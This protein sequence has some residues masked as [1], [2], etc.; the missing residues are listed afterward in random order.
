[1]STE[2]INN[3][4]TISFYSSSSEQIIT[5]YPSSSTTQNVLTHPV[6]QSVVNNYTWTK[7][8]G[9]VYSDWSIISGTN[10]I[11]VMNPYD[12]NNTLSG[13]SIGARVEIRGNEIYST[14]FRE[15]TADS[16]GVA[17]YDSSSS[18]WYLKDFVSVLTSSIADPGDTSELNREFSLDQ[19]YMIIPATDI[20]TREDS[21]LFIFKS[22]SSGWAQEQV[23][24]T[25]SYD[26]GA[27][28]PL[29][30]GRY[31]FLSPKIKGDTIFA[32][33]FKSG[34][35]NGFVAFFKSS[36]A[37]GWAFEKEVQIADSDDSG[38]SDSA[39]AMGVSGV[40]TDFDGT[41][42]VIGAKHGEG[43]HSYHNAAGRIKVLTSSSAGGWVKSADLGLLGL[44]IT[45]DVSSTYGTN[46]TS[47]YRTYDR[48]GYKACSVSGSYIA[49]AA[50]GQNI[51]NSSD[52][53]YHRQKHSV[54]IMK[55]GSTGYNL[56]ARLNDPAANLILSGAS[57]GDTSDSH[58]GE[59]IFLNENV[60][61]V[62][63]PTWES[64]WGSSPAEGRYYV[65]VST[66]AGGWSL[67]QTISNP[68]SG[69]VFQENG[70][71]GDNMQMGYFDDAGYSNAGALGFGVR[72]AASGNLL[73]LGAPYNSRFQ[74]P[75]GSSTISSSPLV[76]ASVIYGSIYALSGSGSFVDHE[77]K[78][79]S[80]E[81][82][83]STVYV[84]QA[85]GPVPF[86]FA[87]RGGFNLRDQKAQ[88]SYK[89]F[90][91]EQKT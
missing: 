13:E 53:K 32:N 48:F 79:Y 18:G 1:M 76:K 25:A 36:S 74:D 46:Y 22:S 35:Y 37:G 16:N 56:E 52:S 59:G 71:S 26:A 88:S 75:N 81:S 4:Y 77:Y 10:A 19:N 28:A 72:P 55:S 8:T 87:Q 6:T 41:T 17:I 69:S 42:A 33:G 83:T 62:S 39:M 65:Y 2:F 47:E 64:E 50:Q 30:Q 58:F 57:S 49:A 54:F 29:N 80:T 61:V 84:A 51:Y 60:L 23:L 44:G 68:Y 24:T 31:A 82:V 66:S 70:A 12:L 3:D 7:A 27:G 5:S 90:I 91:G 9:S 34:Y 63:S 67:D 21:K 45:D 14:V 11:A 38:I 43:A 89:T 40:A 20:S 86:R 85:G 78:T 73:A 15:G